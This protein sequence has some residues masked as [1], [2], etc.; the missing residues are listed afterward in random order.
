MFVFIFLALKFRIL[1]LGQTDLGHALV[2]IA[3]RIGPLQELETQM[4]KDYGMTTP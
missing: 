4:A 3:T 1:T 2:D